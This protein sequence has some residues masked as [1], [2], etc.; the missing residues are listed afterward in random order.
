MY[1]ILDQWNEWWG[2]FVSEDDTY[3]EYV[4]LRHAYPEYRFRIVEG[5]VVPDADLADFA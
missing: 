2:E 4:Q 3:E 5:E 1:Q